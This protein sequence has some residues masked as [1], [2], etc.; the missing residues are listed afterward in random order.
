[1]TAPSPPVPAG[2]ERPDPALARS[3]AAPTPP[4]STPPASTPG[5]RELPRYA[6]R[7][8]GVIA[9]IAAA[10]LAATVNG[11]GYHRD[12]LYFRM[13]AAHPAWGYVDEPPLTPMLVR[14]STELFGDSLWALRL[15]A[16]I[17]AV[18]TVFLVALLC[19]ELGGARFAQT[20]AAFGGAGAFPLVAGHVMLT[21]TPDLVV[22]TL[23]VLFA[24]RA[25]LRDEPRWWLAAGVT[26]GI[27]LYNKQLIVLLLIGLAAGLL[28]SGPRRHLSSRWL[29]AGVGLAVVIALPTVI[30]QATNHWPELHMARAISD[31]KGAND[32]ATYLPFQVI[33]LGLTLA[34]I[35]IA[36]FIA[37]FRDPRWRAI[38]AFGWAY[39]VVSVI[40][41]VS[42]GQV[43]YTFGLLALYY[44]AGCVRVSRWVLGGASIRWGRFG[45][46]AAALAFSVPTSA[47]VALPIVPARSLHGT[48]IAALNQSARDSIGWPTYVREVATAYQ[49][50]SP[51]DRA[52]TAV[53]TSNYGEAG[54]IARFGR[55]DG[56]PALVY[57]GQNQLYFY[58]PPPA[59]D[60]VALVVGIDSQA[61]RSMFGACETIGALDNRLGVANEEQGE[62][63]VECHGPDRPWT[64]LWRSFQHYD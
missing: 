58:G 4:A 41:L 5:P 22:W 64:Q 37:L 14:V 8:V 55:A 31:D 17:C 24:C 52:H 7:P 62:P 46:V 36:G 20:L 63:I 9:A 35:W 61:L 44:A 6:W 28:I 15:P 51:D 11:Y 56:L 33:L 2:H 16:I 1:M 54:A 23:V 34:P 39:P 26:V 30:Y 47:V 32:R 38:R 59:A 18:A 29:W 50:M 57:S 10:V 12:E 21:A 48:G 53:I 43:Y 25:L 42:G 27:G 40:V 13:L 45:W 19:R 49:T 3:S 60:D